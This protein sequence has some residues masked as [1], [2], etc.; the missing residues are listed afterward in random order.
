MRRHDFHENMRFYGGDGMKFFENMRVGKKIAVAFATVGILFAVVVMVYQ[1]T[2]SRSLETFHGEVLSLGE[3]VKS[4]AMEIGALMLQAR[5]AEKDFLLRQDLKYAERH[6]GIIDKMLAG[7][8]QLIELGRKED[9]PTDIALGEEI[10]KLTLSYQGAF[11]SLVAAWQTK[12]L[13][14][15]TGLQGDFRN[16]A[17]KLA[18]R[19]NNMDTAQLK[20]IALQLRRSEKDYRLRGKE[21]YIASHA[22]QMGQF[23][24]TLEATSLSAELKSKLAAALEPYEHAFAQV[25]K[26]K[27]AEGKASK[28]TASHVSK[29]AHGIEKILDANYVDAA[30]RLY[31]EA[32]KH[33]KDYLLRGAQKYV[34]KLEKTVDDMLAR[35]DASKLD[36]G[37]KGEIHGYLKRYRVAFKA[38]VAKDGEVKE[39][40]AR[41]RKAVHD[42]E[43]IIESMVE[44]AQRHMEEMVETTMEEA[45]GKATLAMGLSLVIFL[46]GAL[47]AYYVGRSI[48]KPMERLQRLA[49]AFGHGDLTVTTDIKRHDEIG[50]VAKSISGAIERLRGVIGEVQ[51]GSE[52]VASGS[53]SLSGASQELSRGATDQAASIEQTSA[54]ME[55]MVSTIR[56]NTENAMAT[57]TAVSEAVTAMKQIADKITIIEDIA[58]QTNLLALN[59]AIEAAR[60]GEH[61]KG[62]AVVASEVRKLAERSQAA[63]GEISELS[64][65]TVTVAE[66]A[67]GMLSELVPDIKR[68]AELVQ[69][70]SAASR[71]QQSGAD[72]INS[73]IQ[74]LDQVIQANAG[75]AGDMSH[76]ANELAGHGERLQSSVAYFR[77][78]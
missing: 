44:E 22:R 55:E 45:N 59:A 26:E 2:L 61:G 51:E 66:K 28:Q 13:T 49:D 52:D 60:A 41:M 34:G 19:L 64:G 56:Q 67:G 43:P 25:V 24:Q 23:R 6:K 31:L 16:A 8:D 48:G 15:K 63:A 29:M 77:T 10:K 78:H 53:N 7:A 35:V 1:Q 70:I 42:I 30:W 4:Q 20:I 68:T 38:L 5:R 65:S 12:G 71:E 58:R 69:E 73:A 40:T 18:E 36:D 39:L 32:R 33:E 62:F 76:T 3:A 27:K 47:F 17:H 46:L 54:A 57:G 50:V 9:D 72:Q 37:S 11:Q 75:A 21:K 74:Q 14:P